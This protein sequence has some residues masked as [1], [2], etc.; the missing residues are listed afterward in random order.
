MGAR[1]AIGKAWRG[2]RPLRLISSCAARPN[3]ASPIGEVAEDR[4]SMLKNLKFELLSKADG[5][6]R[7]LS[8]TGE[9]KMEEKTIS[10]GWES[11]LFEAASQG[12]LSGL[13]IADWAEILRASGTRPASTEMRGFLER[14]FMLPVVKARTKI[15]A[16]V[17]LSFV[18]SLANIYR[19][20]TPHLN[21]FLNRVCADM[22]SAREFESFSK[23]ELIAFV[24]ALERCGYTPEAMVMMNIGT[25]LRRRVDELDFADCAAVFKFYSHCKHADDTLFKLL[26]ARLRSTRVKFDQAVAPSL[27]SSLAQLR[28]EGD[29]DFVARTI[30][31]QLMGSGKLSSES[32]VQVVIAITKLDIVRALRPDDCVSLLAVA[33]ESAQ[34]CT[35]RSISALCYNLCQSSWG[36]EGLPVICK[37]LER[38]YWN[39][40]QMTEETIARQ[41]GI[42]IQ[43]LNWTR[44]DAESL[45]C[46]LKLRAS[47]IHGEVRAA[48]KSMGVPKLFENEVKIDAFWG[49]DM[50]VTLVSE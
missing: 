8:K 28:L 31:P 38:L 20:S 12:I 36:G 6:F 50:L 26:Q 15:E 46:L 1:R 40:E 19:R 42:S 10:S 3:I 41:I 13:E 25:V 24:S 32:C 27:L 9:N 29:G 37:A 48:L 44:L 5:V 49:C 30:V 7:D 34:V 45:R 18:S 22:L 33:A 11:H 47:R 43:A 23:V 14:H 2:P 17:A 4:R 16:E 21:A 35:L 39:L